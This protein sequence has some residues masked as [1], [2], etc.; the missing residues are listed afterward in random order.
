MNTNYDLI[1]VG[2]GP[3]GI[4]TAIDALSSLSNYEFWS[5]LAGGCNA[6]VYIL[7]SILTKRFITALQNEE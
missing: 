3:A 4:F 7:S 1:I 5:A 2:A 6:T